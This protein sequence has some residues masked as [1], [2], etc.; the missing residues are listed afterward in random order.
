MARLGEE[1]A[2][3]PEEVRAGRLFTVLAAGLGGGFGFESWPF[4]GGG[5]GGT[6]PFRATEGGRGRPGGGGG[7]PAGGRT[8][9]EAVAMAAPLLRSSNGDEEDEI[10]ANWECTGTLEIKGGDRTTRGQNA[11]E[12]TR[13]LGCRLAG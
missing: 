13:N 2:S 10:I 7:R 1:E 12:F 4:F 11:A 3:F 6:G 9:V 8:I 5:G